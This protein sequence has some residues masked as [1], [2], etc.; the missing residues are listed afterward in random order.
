MTYSASS[1][2][3]KQFELTTE[4]KQEFGFMRVSVTNGYLNLVHKSDKLLRCEFDIKNLP[5]FKKKLEKAIATNEYGVKFD[6]NF[7]SHRFVIAFINLLLKDA[8]EECAK[9]KS[10]QNQEQAAKQ[11]II[12]EI[13]KDKSTRGYFI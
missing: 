13:N 11:Q 3:V 10:A 2:K 1:P 8:E 7:D 4:F 6:A 12:E 5:K 9:Q